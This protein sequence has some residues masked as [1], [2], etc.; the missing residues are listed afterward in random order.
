MRGTEVNSSVRRSAFLPEHIR[1][2]IP[3][4]KHLIHQHLEVMPLVVVNRHPNRAVLA[5]Q[6]T[7]EL[8][9]RQHHAEPLRM[10]QVVVVMLKRALG[11]VGRVDEDALELPPVE[12]QQGLERFEVVAVDQQ[13]VSDL[14][15]DGVRASCW[16]SNDQLGLKGHGLSG[17]RPCLRGLSGGRVNGHLFQQAVGYA[18][19]DGEGAGAVEPVKGGHGCRWFRWRSGCPVRQIARQKWLL[20]F[21]GERVPDKAGSDT[22]GCARSL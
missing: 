11:V 20:P 8:Q 22:G 3:P 18:G 4:P 12:R 15:A 14:C 5:Q 16:V 7:Q 9:A 17:L 13:V 2:K 10:F 6:F 19:G 1:H 21:H